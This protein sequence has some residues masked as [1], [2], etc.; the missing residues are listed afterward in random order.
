[1]F[2]IADD[3]DIKSGKLTDIYFERTDKILKAVGKNPLVKAEIFLKSFP[4]GYSWGVLAGIEETIKLLSGVDK[5]SIR[6]M[7]EGTVFRS[8]QPVMVIEGKYLDF[9]VYE[10]AIL[11]FLCQASGIATKAARCKLAAQD[12]LVYSFGARRVHPAITPMIERSAFIGGAD[13]VSTTLGA[14]LIG[15]DPVGTIPHSLILIMGDT[16]EATKAFNQVIEPEVKRISLIDTFNDEKFEAIRVAEGLGKDLF[17]VRLD[18]PSSRKGD[19]RKILE[20]VR[21]E[22]D[23]RGF[24]EV[25]LAVSGGLDEEDI[26]NL[27]DI[28]DVFGVGT[29]ISGARVLDFSLDI[30][31]IEGKKISKRGKMSGAKKVIRC[32][33]CFSDR[34]VL[35]DKKASDYKCDRCGSAYED[36]FV[37]AVNE[38]K[39]L[40]GFPKASD[41]RNRVLGQ[42]KFL[43]L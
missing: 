3:D 27:R 19:F 41:I 14:K 4:C 25:R 2:H 24:N 15:Q 37:N 16:V 28:A 43:E 36:V 32:S 30:V 23:I 29:A 18:T 13:G 10:T 7:P 17:G 22:L 6:C 33:K 34:I 20:E 40:Y 11:G 35:E 12:K 39:I 5:I 1:M 42:F 31:E 8:F 21:W 26:L 9:G 38:G